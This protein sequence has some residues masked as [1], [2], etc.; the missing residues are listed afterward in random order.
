[1]GRTRNALWVNPFH[2]LRCLRQKVE[3]CF[4]F[5]AATDPSANQIVLPIRQTRP[6]S[7]VGG[8]A[9]CER[10]I[11]SPHSLNEN[12]SQLQSHHRCGVTPDISS[13]NPPHITASVTT[14]HITAS[15]TTP[16]ITASVT[17]PHITASVNTPNNKS[18]AADEWR[19]R[20]KW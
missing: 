2:Q 3:K 1:M 4:T 20:R 19:S 13:V 10:S 16:H 12:P 15:V 5:Q 18:L 6:P 17:T 14:P 11:R 8:R 9:Q 7:S